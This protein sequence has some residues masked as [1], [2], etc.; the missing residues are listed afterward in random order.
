MVVS[1][2]D[3]LDEISL[4][5]PTLVAELKNGSI[6]EYI[7]NAQDLGFSTAVK[8]D[9]LGGDAPQNAGILRDI[10]SGVKGPKRDVVVLN[11]AAALYVSGLAANLKEGVAK[12][13]AALDSGATA[14]TL[15]DWVEFSKNPV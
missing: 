15:A 4:C 1:G 8:E 2:T 10:F 6:S 12:A 11:A 13:K 3:G 5:A 7:L 14:K 9:L